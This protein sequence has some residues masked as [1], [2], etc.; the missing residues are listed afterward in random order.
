MTLFGIIDGRLEDIAQTH[1]AMIA[2]SIIHAS[3]D[4]GND[5][6]E[7]TVAGNELEAFPVIMRDSCAIGGG[8]LSAKHLDFPGPCRIENR[9]DFA[10][11]TDQWGS[12]T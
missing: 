11:G 2:Q 9:R 5:G 1:G 4:P 6:R 12:T 8:S 10:C 3:N 7:Q